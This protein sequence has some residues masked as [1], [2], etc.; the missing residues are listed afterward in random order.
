MGRFLQ[1]LRPGGGPRPDPAI[2]EHFKR[3]AHSRQPLEIEPLQVGATGGGRQFSVVERVD[4]RS[5]VIGRPSGPGAHRPLI[6]FGAYTLLIPAGDSELAG[7]SRVL[8][9]V[10]IKGGASRELH[11]YRLSLPL[12]LHTVSRRLNQRL[13]FG[14]DLMC[15]A[16]V[17]A[18]GRAA[19]IFGSLEELTPTSA[20]LRC[21]APVPIV[22]GAAVH[23]DA[24]LPPPV[25]E[26]RVV[27]EVVGIEPPSRPEDGDRPM[28]NVKF[29]EPV[30]A[31]KRAIS[32]GL[33]QR[34]AA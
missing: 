8:S 27:G 12:E 19:P 15:E 5:I 16:R 1:S 14:G 24:E 31:I 34:P 9:R 17:R 18:E 11:C 29:L 25:G 32:E 7:E 28:L 22:C 30:A 10:R 33:D 23:L 21:R 2:L 3:L 13:L 26:L 20:R 4:D 6:Q